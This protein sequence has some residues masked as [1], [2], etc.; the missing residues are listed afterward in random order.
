[1]AYMTDEY[2]YVEMQQPPENDEDCQAII[3]VY[4][5]NECIAWIFTLELKYMWTFN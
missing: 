1:M 5:Q 2:A 4:I 3:A